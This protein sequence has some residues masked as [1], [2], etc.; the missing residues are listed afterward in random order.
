M[1]GLPAVIALAALALSLAPA[2]RAGSP[3][4]VG[5]V[6]DAAI[7]EDPYTQM[8]LARLVGADTV[9]M[10]VQ[11]TSGETAPTPD[12]L[13]RVEVAAQAAMARGIEPIVAVYN[14]DWRST[15][16][17]D[18][19]R[20]AFVAFLQATVIGLPEVST[21]VVGNE[22]NSGLYWRPQFSSDGADAA[23]VAY[24]QL[25]AASYDAVKSVRPAATV[26]GGALDPRGNDNP[27]GIRQS[28]SPTLFIRHM[29]EAYRASGRTTPVMDVFD[30]HVYPDTS[31]L[32]PSMPH[33]RSTTLT[34][35]DYPRLVSLLGAAFDGTGQ[36]GS[37]LP[38]IYGEYGQE[39][40][41]PPSQASAYSGS[42]PGATPT[43]D[44]ATQA[45]YYTQAL[46]I[47]LCQPNVIGL[48]FFHIE[49]ESDLAGMQSGVFYANGSPK[50][51]FAPVND[52]AYAA[53]AGTLTTCPDSTPPSVSLATPSGD[54]T[55][56]ALASDDVGVGRV[57]LTVNGKAAGVRYAAPY[58]FSWTPTKPGLYH[59]VA[60]AWD[61]A[62]NTA[63]A[64]LD[65]EAVHDSR[66][67]AST[68]STGWRFVVVTTSHLADGTP[69]PATRAPRER[70][71]AP[72]L[73]LQVLPTSLAVA[74]PPASRST[75][76][77]RE[78]VPAL[79]LRLQIPRARL[80]V[81]GR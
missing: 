29:G 67:G 4:H 46:K 26:I 19:G 45:D 57:T 63:T 80:A 24:E 66:S 13:A 62:G 56:T 31:A 58:T 51:S 10:T 74:S 42:Q 49:D 3:L 78:R 55:I 59:L 40:T 72:P 21:F 81:P 8:D 1:R 12:N 30:E 16:F 5:V 39:T 44:E 50:S 22:P 38:I 11:W 32:P 25:L 68:G 64:T 33:L 76:A 61:A 6:E 15:P 23:A 43:I 27:V 35:A 52:A 18:A 73:R 34:E 71:S 7:W 69:G 47:A 28:H 20:A 65:I 70:A 36:P 48:M 9:R 37:T 77:P 54:G 2:A 14:A 53:R 75:P 60:Q 79:P 17:D 41:I